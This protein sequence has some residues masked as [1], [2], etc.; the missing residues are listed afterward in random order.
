MSPHQARRW[1]VGDANGQVHLIVDQIHV[2]IFE[3][4]LNVYFRIANQER[5]YADGRQSGQLPWAR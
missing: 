1:S 2:A 3:F 4:Q 5:L